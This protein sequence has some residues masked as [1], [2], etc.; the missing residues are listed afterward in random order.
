MFPINFSFI[1][2]SNDEPAPIVNEAYAKRLAG[3]AI[4]KALAL[5]GA[6]RTTVERGPGGYG[7]KK[8]QSISFDD[9]VIMQLIFP[10]QDDVNEIQQ[11]ASLIVKPKIITWGEIGLVQNQN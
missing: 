2:E 5:S 6:G 7:R 11:T 9:E 10:V 3:S 4:Y 1:S 8:R